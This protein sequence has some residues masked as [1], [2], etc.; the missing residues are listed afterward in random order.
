MDSYEV[1]I[2][3]DKKVQLKADGEDDALMQ[4]QNRLKNDMTIE[5][6]KNIDFDIKEIDELEREI[7]K[8]KNEEFLGKGKK[9][10]TEV[11]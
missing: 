4:V 3:M 10:E 9:D 6:F 1:H 2:K 11:I 5:D 7:R 8:R